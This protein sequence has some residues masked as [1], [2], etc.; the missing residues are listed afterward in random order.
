MSEDG[1][2]WGRVLLVLG[3]LVRVKRDDEGIF[4]SGGGE[5]VRRELEAADCFGCEEIWQ[6]QGCKRSQARGSCVGRRY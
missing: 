3:M 5:R 2:G 1:V 4:W 6:T